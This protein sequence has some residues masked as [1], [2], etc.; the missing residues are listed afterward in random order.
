[1]TTR[2]AQSLTWDADNRLS[3][4]IEETQQTG[5]LGTEAVTSTGGPRGSSPV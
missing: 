5:F 2:S 3:R 1:M 4:V